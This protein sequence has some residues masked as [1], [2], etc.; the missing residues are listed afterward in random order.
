ME[1]KT[2]SDYTETGRRK[3]AVADALEQLA[4]QAH[5]A[6]SVAD[7]VSVLS[8]L[9]HEARTSNR[10]SRDGRYVALLNWDADNGWSCK[11]VAFLQRGTHY[12]NTNADASLSYNPHPFLSV[13]EFTQQIARTLENDARRARQNAQHY[14]KQHEA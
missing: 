2:A 7:D 14:K 1:A 12:K 13:D 4:E 9:F 6:E 8:E 11:S 3:L 10:K 5:D